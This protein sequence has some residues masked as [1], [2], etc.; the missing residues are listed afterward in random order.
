MDT[1]CVYKCSFKCAGSLICPGKNFLYH[2]F[3]SF[4]APVILESW[5]PLGR[6]ETVNSWPPSL[7]VLRKRLILSGEDEAS[8][9]ASCC[10]GVKFR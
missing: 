1:C 4:F 2:V 7:L 10:P 3:G 8:H 6:M 9:P 5:I